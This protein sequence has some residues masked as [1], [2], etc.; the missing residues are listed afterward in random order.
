[1]NKLQ[2]DELSIMIQNITVNK[3]IKVAYGIKRN[4]PIEYYSIKETMGSSGIFFVYSRHC[5]VFV[6]LERA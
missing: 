1:M 4:F 2:D 5:E 3:C 6:K